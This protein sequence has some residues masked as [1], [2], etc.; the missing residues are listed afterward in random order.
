MNVTEIW[1]KYSQRIRK[2]K[3]KLRIRDKEGC[4]TIEDDQPGLLKTITDIAIF[5]SAADKWRS[6]ESIRSIKT[7]NQ[8][9]EVLKT[10]YGFNGSRSEIYLW[11]IPR[12]AVTQ[13]GKRHVSIVPVKL[14]RAQND[15]HKSHMDADFATATIRHLEELASILGPEQV[16]FHKSG[17]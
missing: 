3:K 9:T 13:E 7:L 6:T 4:L 11:L 5:G 8:L 12:C 17:W 1:K 2:Q 15:E 10:H 16:F 14:I